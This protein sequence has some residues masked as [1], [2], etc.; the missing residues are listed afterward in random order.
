MLIFYLYQIIKMTIFLIIIR[1]YHINLI[2][3]SNY[4]DIYRKFKSLI[5][6]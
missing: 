1:F 6:I 4:R 5:M 3:I 2:Y